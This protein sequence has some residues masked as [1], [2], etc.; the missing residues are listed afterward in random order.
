MPKYPWQ[1]YSPL[2]TH[3]FDDGL[4]V[5]G[6]EPGQLFVCRN[7]QRRFKYDS[8]THTTWAVGKPRSFLAL[9]GSISRRWVGEW[10]AGGPN[11]A[12]EADSKRTKRRVA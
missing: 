4:P 2:R 8:S 7:C 1:S 11:V 12:D 10:C 3:D 5:K 9:E 6:K